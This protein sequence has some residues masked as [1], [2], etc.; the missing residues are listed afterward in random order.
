[1]WKTSNPLQLFLFGVGCPVTFFFFN[2]TCCL[3]KMYLV[4]EYMISP[5]CLMLPDWKLPFYFY[6]FGCHLCKL[7]T[8]LHE[9]PL[10]PGIH[11]LLIFL[12]WPHV[13]LFVHG[14]LQEWAYGQFKI[15]PGFH[16]SRW[17]IPLLTRTIIFSSLTQPLWF[18]FHNPTHFSSACCELWHIP[19]K[20]FIL[21]VVCVIHLMWD[22]PK[23]QITSYFSPGKQ[24]H[25]LVKWTFNTQS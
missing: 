2:D 8:Q 21:T 24:L 18:A 15:S 22:E 17:A 16:L 11:F 10:Q 5:T 13:A 1:M 25:Y 19:S 23:S 4:S 3:I 14:N 6:S 7:Q 12:V 9:T 20:L